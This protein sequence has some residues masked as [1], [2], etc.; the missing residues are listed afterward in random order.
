MKLSEL[1]LFKP[2]GNSGLSWI[3]FRK[4]RREAVFLFTCS[5]SAFDPKRTY[6]IGLGGW[7]E[8]YSVTFPFSL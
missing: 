3:R 1:R 6:Q 4:D 5:M 8:R 7:G 2:E